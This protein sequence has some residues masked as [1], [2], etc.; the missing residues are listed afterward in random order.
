MHVLSPIN[1][2]II[3]NNSIIHYNIIIIYI[4]YVCTHGHTNVSMVFC[5]PGA[6]TAPQ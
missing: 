1:I 6:L 3:C 4:V 2:S 5:I